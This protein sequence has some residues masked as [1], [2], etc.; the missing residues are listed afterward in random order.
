MLK[1]LLAA[2]LSTKL[3]KKAQFLDYRGESVPW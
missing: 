1:I 2:K 3:S